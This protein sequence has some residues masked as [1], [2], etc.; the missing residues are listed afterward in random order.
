MDTDDLDKQ[1]LKWG[2]AGPAPLE[3][4]VLLTLAGIGFL[5]VGL[6]L[7]A[8][9]GTVMIFGGILSVLGGLAL[10]YGL[11]RGGLFLVIGYLKDFVT[12]WQSAYTGPAI[13]GAVLG[14]FLSLL[15]LPAAPILMV[16]CAAL[17]VHFVRKVKG[18]TAFPSYPPPRSADSDRVP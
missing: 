18:D 1:D 7:M 5:C 11:I 4:S 15:Y 8:F 16:V 9:G 2:G 3:N 10:A 14:L 6:P 13:L 12:H 17:A